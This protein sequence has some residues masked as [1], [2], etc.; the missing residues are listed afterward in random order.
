MGCLFHSNRISQIELEPIPLLGLV[1]AKA[2]RNGPPSMKVTMAWSSISKEA[3]ANV[4]DVLDSG[5]LSRRKYMPLFEKKISK[6]H[7]GSFGVFMNSGTDALRIALLTLKEIYKWRN[8]DEVIIPGLTFVATANAVLQSGLSPRFVD[9]QKSTGNIEPNLIASQL[10]PSTRAI[11]A[12]HLFGLPADMPAV[13]QVAKAYRLKVIEDSCETV[14]VHRLTGEMA[15]FSFYISHHVQC[16]VGGMIVGKNP[17]YERVAR[18]Y[19]NHGRTDDGSHFRF[20]RIGYSSRATEM[21]AALGVASLKYFKDT[22]KTRR[23]LAGYYSYHLCGIHTWLA[24]PVWSN[25]HSWMF[26]PVIFPE[27]K[28]GDRDKLMTF[29]LKH[30]VESREAMP[31]VNQPCYKGLYKKGSC[32]NAEEWA[33]NGLLLPLHPQMEPS[34]VKYVSD[35]IKKFFR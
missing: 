5:W 27:L 22:L 28:R 21:E 18:S 16:G 33:A 10:T 24:Y 1:Y 31:L 14:G 13:M 6:M 19:M 25:S 23:R 2:E 35:V 7:G 26:Y 32:P 12:V 3:K 8:G 11:L 15:C 4:N 30:G 20:G 29:L 9:V 17:L 34:D